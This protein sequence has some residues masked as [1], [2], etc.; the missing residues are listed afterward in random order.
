[1][2]QWQNATASGSGNSRGLIEDLP[3]PRWFD[4]LR[5]ARAMEGPLSNKINVL[6][7]GTALVRD[8][9]HSISVGEEDDDREGDMDE[10]VTG[11]GVTDE[12]ICLTGGDAPP[13]SQQPYGVSFVH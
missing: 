9:L 7:G 6:N 8:G 11:E 13:D 12:L 1:M 10:G 3:K 5:S 2:L 4:A